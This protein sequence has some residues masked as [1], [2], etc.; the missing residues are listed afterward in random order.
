MDGAGL[1]GVVAG[2]EHAASDAVGQQR[3]ELAGPAR[4]ERVHGAAGGAV[5]GRQAV[6]LGAVAFTEADHERGGVAVGDGDSGRRFE[7]GGEAGPGVDRFGHERE[8]GLLAELGFGRGGEYPG[9]DARRSG[10]GRGVVD[11]DSGAEVR[12]PP[13][14][15]EPDRSGADDGEAHQ[16]SPARR[17]PSPGPG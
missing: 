8:E 9:G 15:G 4:R 3:L 1:D 17:P 7:L 10:T 13:G 14:D 6:D 12:G 16:S 2:D 5:E 11:G